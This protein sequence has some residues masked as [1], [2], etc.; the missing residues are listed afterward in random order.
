M[1]S[2]DVVLKFL[3]GRML[4]DS[5]IMSSSVSPSFRAFDNM[6]GKILFRANN[7]VYFLKLLTKKVFLNR[8]IHIYD[9]NSWDIFL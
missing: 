4:D 3:V 9:S 5:S 7:F 1:Y 6:I 2:I 8:H